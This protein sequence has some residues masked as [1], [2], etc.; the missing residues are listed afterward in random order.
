MQK[1]DSLRERT[2]TRQSFMSLLKH[3][4]TPLPSHFTP[5]PSLDSSQYAEQTPLSPQA[6]LF[7]D[8][9]GPDTHRQHTVWPHG[10]V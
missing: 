1:P 4:K 7:K 10:Q 2:V 3:C 9:R 6:H 8:T 5:I